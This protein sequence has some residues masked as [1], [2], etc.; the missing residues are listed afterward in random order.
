M[1]GSRFQPAGK[2]GITAST[3]ENRTQ[4]SKTVEKSEKS[5]METEEPVYNIFNNGRKGKSQKG[6]TSV[7][8]PP[9]RWKQGVRFVD[10]PDI[11]PPP[12]QEL[13]DEEMERILDQPAVLPNKG[14]SHTGYTPDMEIPGEDEEDP[15][16]TLP[17]IEEL[18]RTMEKAWEDLD[19]HKSRTSGLGVT[20][21]R[22]PTKTVGRLFDSVQ[23]LKINPIPTN[24]P[25]SSVKESNKQLSS[26]AKE[27]QYRIRTELFKE[28]AEEEVANR[29]FKQKVELTPKEIATIS[30]KVRRIL[31]R[32]AQNK[33]VE[34]QKRL[35]QPVFLTTVGEN[36]E[37]TLEKTHQVLQKYIRLEDVFL[38]KEDVFETL[39][40]DVGNLKAGSIV[41]RDPVE[42]FRMDMAEDDDRRN[43]TIVASTGNAL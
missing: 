29:I 27:P 10:E 3:L 5:S 9:A 8:V 23:P 31:M 18:D 25:K 33:R 41:Q 42:A 30:P 7:Y 22:S 34:P 24:M 16:F 37:E 13:T 12:R 6:Q 26:K 4:Q 32:K 43:L 21:P 40:Q 38:A 39:T 35:S 2:E 1:I 15:E 28:G 17:E 19:A 14:S 36:G 11:V 20:P